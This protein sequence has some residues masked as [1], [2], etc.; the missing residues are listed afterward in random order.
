MTQS[1]QPTPQQTAQQ[2][3]TGCGCLLLIVVALA[4]GI[5]MCT[6]SPEPKTKTKSKNLDGN[7]VGQP[8]VMDSEIGCEL[9][10]KKLLRDPESLQRDE[11]IATEASPTAWAAN[12]SFRSRN[13]FGGMNLMQAVCTFDGSE[14]TVTVT[15]DQ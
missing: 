4:L 11:Y 15:G 2:T 12:M 5:G 14:Y 10:L 13:G 7:E 1:P 9:T 3:A 8:L 6:S